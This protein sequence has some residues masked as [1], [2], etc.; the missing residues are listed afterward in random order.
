LQKRIHVSLH[1]LTGTVLAFGA[2]AASSIWRLPPSLKPFQTLTI[3]AGLVMAVLAF[4]RPDRRLA[5]LSANFCLLLLS[6]VFVAG[7]LE[8][9]FRAIGFDFAHEEEN[10]RKTPP[11]YRQPIVESGEVYFRRPGPETWTGRVLDIR[12]KQLNI[13][14]NPYTN[15]T[16]ITVK[17]DR[18]GF[19]NEE[20][21]TDWDIAVT[22]DSFTELGYLSYEQLFTTLLGKK[23]N[24]RVLNLGV[25]QTGPLSQVSYLRDYGIAP[26]TKQVVIVFFEGNDL[27]DLKMENNLLRQFRE[28]GQRRHR[29]FAKRSSVIGAVC[30]TIA[31]LFQK[32][33]DKPR[34][35]VT[36]TFS[37]AHGEVPMTFLYTPPDRMHLPPETLRQFEDFF[38]RYGAFGRERQVEAWLVYAPCKE[39]ILHGLVKFA[40]D[41]PNRFQAWQPTDLPQVTADLA[42][43]H[44]VRFIDLT[45]ALRE[46]T[47]RTR[48][49]LFNSIYDTHFNARGSAV[50]AEELAQKL[51]GPDR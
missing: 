19:R 30:R 32:D 5:R 47:L 12:L 11:Y 24:A 9:F 7:T 21:L 33:P 49:L 51:R 38:A 2:I 29:Q 8:I 25:S 17:Y 48:E 41:A 40:K 39:R 35:M 1:L 13:F 4:I 14:P 26:S 44:G 23:S 22:G 34:P 18:F 45:P 50:V 43:K 42:A 31:S 16:A 10:W 6:G 15:E 28:T 3:V 27:D 36:A 46:T 20:G 37:S